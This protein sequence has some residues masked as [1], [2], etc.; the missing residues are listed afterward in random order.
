MAAHR[1]DALG[2]FHTAAL[3]IHTATERL[4]QSDYLKLPGR[5]REDAARLVFLTDTMRNLMTELESYANEVATK[6]PETE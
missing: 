6:Y 2:K 4:V 3:A 5:A 1:P